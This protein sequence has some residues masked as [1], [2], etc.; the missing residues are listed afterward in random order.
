MTKNKF[1]IPIVLLMLLLII[2]S[3]S[4][5]I[6][7]VK[8]DAQVEVLTHSSYI[9]SLGWLNVVGEVQNVGDQPVEYVKISAT[10]YDSSNT[11]VD[12]SFTFSDLDVILPNRKSPFDI[13]LFD[14]SQI[15]KVDHYEL[16]VS[17]STTVS[18]QQSL[19][20]ISHSSYIDTLG[21]LNIVGEVENSASGGATYVKVIAT[22]YDES[23][24]VINS[25]FDITNDIDGGQK[26]PFEILIISNNPELVSS[27]ELTAE[28]SEF[29]EIPEVN[30]LIGFILIFTLLGLII[31]FN[32]RK[33]PATF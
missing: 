13:L 32:D 12:T 19:R 16:S 8:A 18:K 4:N 30:S 26:A 22:C 2:F 24:T 31:Y 25:G 9:D 5:L 20:I 33:R 17:F 1:S 3:S 11:V 14:E 23:G 10:F 6:F 27:Y 28:S 7:P 15:S 21:W 29:A